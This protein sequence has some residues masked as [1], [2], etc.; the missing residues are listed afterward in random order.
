MAWLRD[1]TDIWRMFGPYNIG[2]LWDVFFMCYE[3]ISKKNNNW[4]CRIC[5][6]LFFFVHEKKVTLFWVVIIDKMI[7]FWVEGVNFCHYWQVIKRVIWFLFYCAGYH[8]DDGGAQ[9][10][11]GGER[12][13]IQILTTPALGWE[14]DYVVDDRR[15]SH[16]RNGARRS[17][18]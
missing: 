9:E 14:Y 6:V 15:F 1:I 4:I 3:A 8:V 16:Y 11:L 7:N 18:W 17:T 2:G 12:R 5:Q 10:V 13:T